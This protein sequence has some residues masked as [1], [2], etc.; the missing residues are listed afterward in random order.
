MI[1]ILFVDDEANVLDGLRRSLRRMRPEWEMDFASSGEA[2]LRAMSGKGYDV[3]V[4]DM[5]MP[6]MSGAEFLDRVRMGHP[7]VIRIMLSGHANQEDILKTVGVTHQFLSKPCDLETLKQT[8]LRAWT[9]RNVLSCESVR[10]IVA[11]VG[12]LPSL[13]KLFRDLR[14]ELRSPESSFESVARIVSQDIAMTAKVLQL[15]N[16]AFFG[17]PR[18]VQSISEAISLLGLSTL[19]SLLVSAQAFS[20]FEGSRFEAVS[21]KALWDHSVSV[22]L[23][24]RRIAELQHAGD[25]LSEQAF[26]AGLL[27]EVGTLVLATTDPE[28]YG[29]VISRARRC[30]VPR[31]QVEQTLFGCTH[32]E[33]GAYLTGL[34]GLP[35]PIV[36]AV[37]YQHRPEACVNVAFSPLTAVHVADAVAE[38]GSWEG[39][40]PDPVS[41]AY[42][43][44]LGLATEL[45]RWQ[46]ALKAHPA[47]SL[48]S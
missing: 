27:H 19:Q 30:A 42:L 34:W 10:K 48:V 46:E 40:P 47:S 41:V 8:I 24:A 4:S 21:M 7:G 39:V 36:E 35:D 44:S 23:L 1:R 9:L 13:P 20:V 32:A 38:E 14:E 18:L 3:V 2:A 16:S 31:T 17:L 43:E 11:Q 26:M 37:A 33:A 45:P 25:L 12:T 28:G 29:Q 22:S 6:I 5:R 15:V